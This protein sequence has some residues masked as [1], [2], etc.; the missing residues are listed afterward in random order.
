MSLRARFVVAVVFSLGVSAAV[1]HAETGA[2]VQGLVGCTE[3]AS[4][5][6]ILERIDDGV[7]SPMFAAPCSGHGMHGTATIVYLGGGMPD[8][9]RF[10][11]SVSGTLPGSGESV[12]ILCPQVTEPVSGP[13]TIVYQCGEG[14]IRYRLAL[15]VMPNPGATII[16]P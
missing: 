12:A 6:A 1:I 11:A 5:T 4:G 13:T 10:T 3:A 8:A 9:I 15:S 16:Q 7:A 14:P 2:T